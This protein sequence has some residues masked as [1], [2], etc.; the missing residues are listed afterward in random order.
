[1]LS[2]NIWPDQTQKFDEAWIKESQ[3][4]EN[5]IASVVGLTFVAKTLRTHRLAMMESLDIIKYCLR[6]LGFSP[7]QLDPH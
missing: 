1:M 4:V 6:F 2:N 3:S 5:R 7:S